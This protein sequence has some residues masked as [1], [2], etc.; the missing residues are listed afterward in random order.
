MKPSIYNFI[1]PIEDPEKVMLFNSLTTSLAEVEKTHLDLL[2]VPR[3]DYDT[4]PA[5]TKQFIDGL[6]QGGYV[7]DDEADDLKILKFAYNSGKYNRLGIGITIAPTLRCNFAC[8]YCYEQSGE[9]QN[10]RD[11]QNAFMPENVQQELLK[12]IE[13]AKTVKGVFITSISIPLAATSVANKYLKL[14]RLKSFITLNLSRCSI[15]P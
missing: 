8:T 9:N 15:P 2:D 3:F 1:W 7:L 14:P 13:A 4:L 11:G 6:K 10:K 5:D 12:F